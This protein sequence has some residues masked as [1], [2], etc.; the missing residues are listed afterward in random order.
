MKIIGS[1]VMLLLLDIV[2]T[3]VHASPYGEWANYENRGV[4]ITDEGACIIR[5][6]QERRYRIMP[7]K[8]DSK[9]FDGVYS[10]IF[11][12]N[13]VARNKASCSLEGHEPKTAYMQIRSWGIEL[14][15]GTGGSRFTA[16][17]SFMP[18]CKGEFCDDRKN[19]SQQPFS[20]TLDFSTSDVLKDFAEDFTDAEPIIFRPIANVQRE[21]NT[22]AA[23]FLSKLVA[24]RPDSIA[25][26]VV[27]N[28]DLK[29]LPR[30]KEQAIAAMEKYWQTRLVN[31]AGY[32]IIQAYLMNANK[33]AWPFAPITYIVVSHKQTDG[34][35]VGEILELIKQD[36]GWKIL[37]LQE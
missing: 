22:V 13:W 32:E 24:L 4:R 14:K 17:A 20:T 18:P 31:N 25:Q 12:W 16:H 27:K 15:S 1:L 9:Q 28:V 21:S 5:V 2:A 29:T 26:F 36:D 3:G 23:E 7:S 34:T 37:M 10:T 8:I 19:F 11:H 30:S 6:I 35:Q 33:E